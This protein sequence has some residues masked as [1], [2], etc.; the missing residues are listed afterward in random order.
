MT[1][2]EKYA[3]LAPKSFSTSYG[4]VPVVPVK[5]DMWQMTGP[6]GEEPEYIICTDGVDSR[7]GEHVKVFFYI[8]AE[9]S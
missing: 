5:K 7:T 8:A 9:E 3:Y 1:L 6:N 2:D 4:Q